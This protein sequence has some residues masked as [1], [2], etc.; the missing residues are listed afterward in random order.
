MLNKSV[1]VNVTVILLL[2]ISCDRKPVI[3][4]TETKTLGFDAFMK[5]T[6][7]L[8]TLDGFELVETPEGKLLLAD[9]TKPEGDKISFTELNPPSAH[10]EALSRLTNGLTNMFPQAIKRSLNQ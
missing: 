7:F 6:N 4:S 1:L 10:I 9:L 8:A 3:M 5:E 2:T